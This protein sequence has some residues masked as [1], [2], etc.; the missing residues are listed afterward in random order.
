MRAAAIGPELLRALAAMPFLDR[1]ELAALTGRSR[2]AV[3]EAVERLERAG[4]VESVPHGTELFPTTRRYFLNSGGLERLAGHENNGVDDLLRHHPVSDRWRRSLLERLDALAVIYRLASSLAALRG[5]AGFR[6]YRGHPLDA[7]IALPGGVCLGILRQGHTADRT[8]FAKRLWRLGRGPLPGA[9]LVLVHDGMR[10]RQARR[11]LSGAA[12]PAYLALERDAALAEPN[13]PVWRVPSG[14]SALDLRYV[15]DRLPPGGELPTEPP[16]SKLAIPGDIAPDDPSALPALLK[17]AEKRAL[18][19]LADWPWIRQRDLAG[20]LAVSETRVSHILAPL[21]GFGLMARVAAAA[22]GRPAL[23]DRG[24][25]LLARRDRTSVGVARK[26]WSVE[27]NGPGKQADWRNVSGGRSRQLLRNLDHTTAVHGFT[28]AL[29]KQARALGWEVM[30]LDPPHRAVRR[31]PHGGA[32]RSVNPDAFGILRKGETTR[33]FFLE[34]ERRAVRPATMSARLA[35]YLRYYSSH[36]PTDDHG[37][38]PQVLV[39]FDNDIAAG[40]F[41]Q[42]ACEELKAAG[43]NV[44]LRVSDSRTVAALGPLG[45]AWRSQGGWE[46]APPFS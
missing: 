3:Y 42:V 20:L 17:P 2:G 43:V 5:I 8:A 45:R 34:W 38:R 41:L 10:L 4:S 37:V 15:L 30:Q 36:R 24:L 21:E 33:P 19:L 46:P 29:A 12:F 13:A 32:W 25:A 27:P 40:H 9:V 1:L 11:M 22:G 35:P 26:R 31:F 16:P 6:W 39:V 18:D 28:S 44:P 23:T 14:N 7:G